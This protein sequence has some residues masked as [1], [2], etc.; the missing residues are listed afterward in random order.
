MKDGALDYRNDGR[1]PPTVINRGCGCCGAFRGVF[2]VSPDLATKSFLRRY[3]DLIPGSHFLLWIGSPIGELD[4]F[5]DARKKGHKHEID[6][7]Q[8]LNLR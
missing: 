5:N 2:S 3:Q 4:S 6:S 8:E 1:S 7:A